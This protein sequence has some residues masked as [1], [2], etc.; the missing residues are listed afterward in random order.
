MLEIAV[1]DINS[2]AHAAQQADVQPEE[3]IFVLTGSQLQEIISRAIQ[4]LQ[5]EL[6]DLKATVARQGEKIK[7]LEV[8]QDFQAENSFIQL[9][10]INDLRKKDPGKTEISRA[11]KIEKYLQAR[12]DHKANFETLKGT[13]PG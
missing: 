8:T 10:L 5:A 9:Q 11:E 1:A 3:P 13:P 6:Q 2:F 7:A 12:P 4:P